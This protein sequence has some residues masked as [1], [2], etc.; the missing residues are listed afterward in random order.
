MALKKKRI[1]FSTY[2]FVVV[3]TIT[4]NTPIYC[5]GGFVEGKGHTFC[6]ERSAVFFQK[7]CGVECETMEMQIWSTR[8]KTKSRL[9]Y[10]TLT[11]IVTLTVLLQVVNVQAGKYLSLAERVSEPFT[12]QTLPDVSWGRAGL[13]YQLITSFQ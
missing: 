4:N 8:W 9:L 2:G 13:V 6:S 3:T 10:P 1:L 5:F 7:L 11:T 12:S